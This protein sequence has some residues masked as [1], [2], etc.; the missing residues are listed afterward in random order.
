MPVWTRPAVGGLVTGILAVVA[1]RYL[2]IGGVNGGGYDTLSMALSGSL[3]FK[4]MAVLCVFK[5]IATVFSYSSGGAGGIFAPALFIGGMLGGVVGIIDVSLLGNTGSDIGAFALVGMGAV[6]AGVVRAPI[7][8]VL[9]IFEMTGSYGLILPLMIANMSAYALARHYRP[10]PIYEALIEQDGIHLP[11]RKKGLGHALEQM[12]VTDAIQR[13]AVVLNEGL[14]V[15]EAVEFIRSYEFTTFPVVDDDWHCVGTI[16]EM[17]LRRNLVNK[18]QGIFIRDIADPCPTIFPDQP[19]SQAVLKM[20]AAHV[21]QLSVIERGDDQKI[22]G[23]VTMSDIV[24][25]Q[26]GVIGDS[27]QSLLRP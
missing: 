23:I 21:R 25:V 13:G 16:T 4:V 20:D 3:T 2:A 22:V 10:T 7:T 17:R 5:L 15:A 1:L 14:T 9:I 12:T 6:F 26:A 19:L 11:H 27:E 18:N 24:R 8:S